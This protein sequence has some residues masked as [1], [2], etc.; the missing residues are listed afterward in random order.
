MGCS[1]RHGPGMTRPGLRSVRP[2]R[3]DLQAEPGR[4]CLRAATTTQAQ[5]NKTLVMLGGPKAQQPIVLLHGITLFFPV[6]SLWV[7]SY[8]A[9]VSLFCV[10]LLFGSCHISNNEY[11]ARY[12]PEQA[13]RGTAWFEDTPMREYLM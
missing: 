6:S 12:R 11:N 1:P 8:I 2:V 5:P 4:A 9:R 7:V 3:P 13:P 10:P